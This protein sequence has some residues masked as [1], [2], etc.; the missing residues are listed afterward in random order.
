M[1]QPSVNT[2]AL[3]LRSYEQ[4]C[5]S[6]RVDKWKLT[7][8]HG[9]GTP[10]A[11]SRWLQGPRWCCVQ[12]RT[13]VHKAELHIATLLIFGCL[14]SPN[15]LVQYI[16]ESICHYTGELRCTKQN[17]TS[18]FSGSKSF[19]CSRTMCHYTRNSDSIILLRMERH[20]TVEAFVLFLPR[21]W[22]G[23]E[24]IQFEKKSLL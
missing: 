17:F 10:S 19:G 16:V 13:S 2:K 4:M 18:I 24:A 8:C 14:P 6:H 9:H 23:S 21:N 3:F 15:P 7:S 20:P 1:Q 22:V 12:E 5:L 11:L